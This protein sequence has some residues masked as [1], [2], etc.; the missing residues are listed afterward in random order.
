MSQNLNVFLVVN[1]R[2]ICLPLLGICAGFFLA[3]PV[4]AMRLSDDANAEKVTF[5]DHVLPILR[6]RCAS[7]HNPDKKSGGLDLSNYTTLMLGGGSGNSV[8]PGDSSGSHLLM[9]VSHEEEPHMP[10]G[11]GKIP[12]PEIATIRKWIEGG[13]LENK[14]SKARA[15]K[16]SL[17]STGGSSMERPAVV[18]V[19]PRLPLEPV[20]QPKMPGC[21]TAMATSPWAPIIAI[22]APKQI[23]LYN[24]TT[25]Q[26]VG[27]LEFPEGQI[28]ILQFSRNGQVLLAGGGKD[29]AFGHVVLWDVTT[30]ERIREV[31][32]ELD[33]VLAADISPDHNLVALGGP[34]KVVKVYS[35]NDG[36][37]LYE[38]RKH[39]E[40]ITAIAF[41]PDGVLLASGDRNGGAF[42]W[43]APTGNQ[44]LELK[45]HTDRITDLSWRLDSNLL[46]SGSQDTT[47]RLWEMENGG[48]V[49]NWGAHGAGVTAI[50]FTR[51]GNIASCGRDQVAKIWNQ[52]GEAIKQFPALGDIATAV[53]FCDETA[54][55]IAGD[56]VG[57]IQ[58]WAEADGAVVGTLPTKLPSLAERLAAAQQQLAQVTAAHEPV[59]N[60]FA[61]LQKTFDE[62]RTAL[63]A[64]TGTRQTT[65]DAMAQLEKQMVTTQEQL[66]AKI[67]EQTAWQSE[68][69]E[70][71]KLKPE[72]QSLAEKAAS[73]AA[74]SPSDQELQAAATQLAAK[75]QQVDGRIGELTAALAQTTEIRTMTEQQMAAM[76]EQVAA[77]RVKLDE[78]NVQIAAMEKEQGTMDAALKEKQV[79]LQQAQQNLEAGQRE[80]TRWQGE[81]QFV[82]DLKSLLELRLA[83]EQT[84][85]DRAD[86]RAI[87]EEELRA[88]QQRL[89]AA[90]QAVGQATSEV[91]AVEQRISD[92]KKIGG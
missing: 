49:K 38:V 8:E 24:T 11:G 91:D 37:L 84:A 68:H 54:R 28:N 43:E 6:T 51:A 88:V 33:T 20:L 56:W 4:F 50:Q 14:S 73:V 30:G 76:T 78:M 80:L 25:L 48:Q 19:P 64:A 2:P 29:A 61:A 3:L 34:Q 85:D 82:A 46:A 87:I 22:A 60:E 57:N 44:Y 69:D 92:L 17:A 86:A 81:V 47:I 10:P 63:A 9:L 59:A 83:A 71:S 36:S 62:L 18:A 66:A 41:S 40:W 12:D 65:M 72:L 39:T 31:G 1:P 26:L 77:H 52:N 16:K 55:V 79:V 27:I 58:V 90:T 89:D 75:V 67:A 35:T 5:E 21:V 13:A 53:A 74:I 42:V 32:D 7:C 70:K 23:L 15:V 45:G